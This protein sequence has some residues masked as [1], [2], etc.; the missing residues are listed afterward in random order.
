MLTVDRTPGKPPYHILVRLPDDLL[1]GVTELARLKARHLASRVEY[2]WISRSRLAQNLHETTLFMQAYNDPDCGSLQR[3]S[4]AEL[5]FYVRQFI[6]FKSATDPRTWKEGQFALSPISISE[7]NRLATDIIAVAEFYDLPIDVLL[8]IGAMENN[9]LN[10]P[11]DLNNAIW[12]KRAERDDIVLQKKGRKVWILNSSIGIWQITRQSLRHAQQLFL[13]D[14]RDYTTLPERLRP[15]RQLDMENLNPDVLTTYAGLLLRDLLDH[16]D[17]DTAMATGAYNGT[18]HHPNFR[19]AA[20]VEMVASYA[21]KVIGNAA[22]LSRLAASPPAFT[23][24]SEPAEIRPGSSCCLPE[25][26]PAHTSLN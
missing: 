3:I 23:R 9:F 6:R 17:G 20:G 24:E 5:Q 10:A 12:K 15:A 1:S 16:S 7:A 11:G 18:I 19:Y 25:M 26:N 13:A 2:E 21:R 4:S 22:E 14:K 8:G